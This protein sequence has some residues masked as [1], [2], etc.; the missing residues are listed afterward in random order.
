MDEKDL[1]LR[2]MLPH[3]D[4][5][6]TDIENLKKSDKVKTY[7][8]LK[9][10]EEFR[11]CHEAAIIE[12]HGRLIAAWYNNRKSELAGYTPIRFAV[13]EDEGKNWCLPKTVAGDPSGKILYCPPVFGID[14]DRLYMFLNRMVAPDHIHSLDL[15]IYNQTENRFDFLWSEPLPFK[16]NTNV[17]KIDNGKL[18]IPGRFGEPDGFPQIPGVIISDSGTINNE[19]RGI[20]ITGGKTLPDGTEFIHPEVSLIIDKNRIYAFC[21]NDKRNVPIVF[22]SDDY[23]EHWSG[24]HASDIPLASS[25]IYS[26]TLSDGRNYVIGNLKG[27]RKTLYILFSDRNTMKFRRGIILQD[28]FSEEMG[29]GYQWSYPSAYESNGKLFVVYTVSYN[30]EQERGIVISVIDI[31]DLD[32]DEVI[33]L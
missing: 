23:G 9:P 19:W 17:C 10:S 33:S 11:F 15:Y 26:G 30:S 2:N 4:F 16:V 29:C 20:R 27:D 13:S 21:R 3:T 12:F 14:D 5:L 7:F 22:M 1:I 28:G 18:I 25:K 32:R 6:N 8:I 31:S 24:P